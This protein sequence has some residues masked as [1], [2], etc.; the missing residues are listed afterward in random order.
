MILHW[1]E[2]QLVTREVQV[3]VSTKKKAIC[4]AVSSVGTL[5]A[6]SYGSVGLLFTAQ[7]LQSSFGVLL[8]QLFFL[9]SR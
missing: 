7:Q 4:Q 3:L 2:S 9:R 5:S 1:A 8:D 6:T